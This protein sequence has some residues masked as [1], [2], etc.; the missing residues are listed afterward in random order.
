MRKTN[1]AILEE[2]KGEVLEVPGIDHYVC[3]ACGETAFD[4]CDMKKL[5]E[6]LDHAYR[7]RNGFLTPE[8]IKGLRKASGRRQHK[9]V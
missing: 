3:D 2:F 1:E 9:G 4:A 8:E 6:Q 5:H 7:S